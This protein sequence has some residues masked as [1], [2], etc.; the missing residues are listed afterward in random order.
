MSGI[1]LHCFED[2]I[3]VECFSLNAIEGFIHGDLDFIIGAVLTDNRGNEH[4]GQIVIDDLV[5]AAQVSVNLLFPEHTKTDSDIGRCNAGKDAAFDLRT[6]IIELEFRKFAVFF[7]EFCPSQ[8]GKA[9]TNWERV[10]HY[11]GGKDKVG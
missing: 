11:E 1:F 2:E 9:A 3:L 7:L 8:P 5:L 6:R 10:I 4:P